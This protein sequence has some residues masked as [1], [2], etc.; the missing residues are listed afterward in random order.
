MKIASFVVDVTPPVDY[1]I[2]YGINRKTD[3]PIHIRGIIIDDGNSRA[4]LAS[5]E[6]IYICGNAYVELTQL[7]AQSAGT[8]H[9]KVFLH[10]V[11]QH[12]S[13]R[14]ATEFNA[15]SK[16]YK[17]IECTPLNYYQSIKDKLKS[18][19]QSAL[20]QFSEVKTLA[21]AERRVSNLASNRRLLDSNNRIYAMRYSGCTDPELQKEPVGVID[22]LLR[23]VGFI[24]KDDNPIAILHFYATHPMAVYNLNMASSDTPGVALDYVAQHSNHPCLNIYFNGCGANLTFGKYS[25]KDPM[26]N[27]RVL[28]ERL[29]KA[30]LENCQSLHPQAVGDIQVKRSY[31]DFPL[32]SAITDEAIAR[33]IAETENPDKKVFF[34]DKLVVRNDFQKWN[35][36]CVSRL[37]IGREVNIL[38]IPGESMVEYQ[39]Y[40]QSLVPERFLACASYSNGIYFYIPTA[41]MFD[42]GGY[43]A[44]F[45]SI[46]TPEVERNMKNAIYECLKDLI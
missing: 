25:L 28:G 13:V 2:A 6:V 40:A 33:A 36:A 5:A 34:A 29:G 39:L 11:H 10:A 16:K 23:S 35:K 42:E 45:G 18:H 30:L 3:T 12:D 19:I 8:N 15:T 27:R 26:E 38:S 31:F 41:I 46:T 14:I 22:P 20:F 4:V 21:T 44:E 32:D 17:G 9:E 43:E 37:S 7:I 24:G 1:P